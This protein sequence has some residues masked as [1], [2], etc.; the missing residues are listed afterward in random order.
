MTSSF[1]LSHINI[2]NSLTLLLESGKAKPRPA[3]PVKIIS[4]FLSGGGSSSSSDL[5]KHRRTPTLGSISSLATPSLSRSNSKKDLDSA[6]PSTNSSFKSTSD[7]AT[8]INPL[9]RLEETFTGYVAA[10]QARKGNVVGKVLRNRASADELSVNAIYNTFIENP[11]DTRASSEVTVDVL[12]S[13]FEK[14]TRMAW[15][16]Q[17]GPVISIQT[18]Q[19]LQDKA[20]RLFPGDF[21]EYIRLIF[22]DMAPQNR[23]AFVAIIKLLADLLAG[24][25]NDGDRGALT[26]AFTELLVGNNDPHSYINLLDRLVEDCDRIFEDLGV[27]ASNGRI[28]PVF[29][30]F[31]SAIRSQGSFN[32]GSLTSNTSLRK[33]FGFDT[34]LRQNS[35]REDENKPSMWRT[36]SKTGRSPAAGEQINGS[37]KGLR[38][39][40]KT[41][42]MDSR[43]GTPKRPGSRD[44][45]TVLGAFDRPSSSHVLSNLGTIGQSP[46]PPPPPS[47]SVT[48]RTLRGKRRSSLSDLKGLM[49]AATLEST[50]APLSPKRPNQL[51]QPAAEI[52]SPRTPSPVKIPVSRARAYTISPTQKENS[53]PGHNV[54]STLPE[55]PSTSSTTH[56]LKDPW[57]PPPPRSRPR[58]RPSASVSH[59]PMLR[60]AAPVFG[61]PTP[62]GSKLPPIPASKAPGLTSIPIPIPN[63]VPGHS[64]RSSVSRSPPPSPSKLRLQSPLKLRGRPHSD[65]RGIDAEIGLQAELVR[66]GEEMARLSAGSPS[67]SGANRDGGAAAAAAAAAEVRALAARVAELDRRIPE[68]VRGADER[69]DGARR[70]LERSVVVAEQRAKG[71]DQLYREASAENEL[72][73]ER[74]NGELGRIVR[75]LRG[76]G[77]EEK[78][79]LVRRVKEAGE[80]GAG[81]RRENAMLRRE[82]V[83]LR[84]L[85]QGME[86]EGEK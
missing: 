55:R 13:A 15:T 20:A 9:V 57:S 7:E 60:P 52:T 46:S 70:E 58:H 43:L 61:A 71:L 63:A 85:V 48:E 77:R 44:R 47:T 66:I 78:E 86:V 1:I 12:F 73:Y 39:R 42:D 40:S 50:P 64:H 38:H 33:R 3:S 41:I 8:V 62:F 45:P 69:H 81:L 22:G 4:S 49:A 10:L 84:A 17:M 53:R 76:K 11:F 23:R 56:A 37:I 30:S 21:A 19:A 75:A 54:L 68:L 35:K 5:H 31:N 24:C 18:L 32:A 2:L 74:F 36:L 65:S 67:R 83:G 34:L 6:V 14:F 51:L 28:T 29:G 80:E 27:G 72:L 82:V 16:D 25:G 79:E 26:A 59:I